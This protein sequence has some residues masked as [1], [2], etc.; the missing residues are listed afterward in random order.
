MRPRK[1]TVIKQ[2][3]GTAQPSR[4]LQNEVKPQ[5][6]TMPTPPDWLS[7]YAKDEWYTQTLEMESL[8]ILSVMDLSM[9]AMYCQ[10]VGIFR[11]AQEEMKDEEL[12]VTTPN[13]ALQPNPLLGIANKAS[14]SALKIASQFGF[15]PSARTRIGANPTQKEEDPLEALLKRRN[16]Q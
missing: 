3:Q 11:Q 10:Q 9:L 2:L 8:G 12:V 16:S 6:V 13:G 14:D 1:P 7:D 4:I 15:T 5:A